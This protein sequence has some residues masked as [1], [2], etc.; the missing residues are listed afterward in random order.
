MSQITIQ[1]DKKHRINKSFIIAG[2][3][4]NFDEYGMAEIPNRYAEAILLADPTLI[5]VDE[6]DAKEFAKL[7]EERKNQPQETPD[8]DI[9]DENKKFKKEIKK[10]EGEV[11]KLTKEND[12]LKHQI[13]DFESKLEET[14]VETEEE[15]QEENAEDESKEEE[16]GEVDL[17]KMKK[18]EL[19]ALC[20]KL[21]L[22]KEEWEE[23][24]KAD[25][26]KYIES[27]LEETNE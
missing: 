16:E 18:D 4:V 7:K 20:G 23:L 8:I 25:L 5:I 26:V 14:P 24:N 6:E 22:E 19:Q 10:L 3:K 21:E 9:I 1:T 12:D 2:K 27:K 17:S 11:E 13:V 15:T